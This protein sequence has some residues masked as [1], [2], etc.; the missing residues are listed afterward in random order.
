MTNNYIDITCL[1]VNQPIGTFYVG[2]I[3]WMDLLS[4]SRKDIERIRSEEEGNIEGYFGIQRELSENRLKE[5]S[6][7]VSFE[8]ATFPNSIVISIDSIYYNSKNDN[9][10][11]NIISFENNILRLNNNGRIAKII[12]GQH[13][14]FGIEKYI[15]EYPLFNDNYVFDLI[16][17]IFID[18]DEEYQSN[19]FAT[20]NKAQTKVN[21]SLVYDLYSLA[22]SR[23][24]QRTVHNIVKLLNEDN[25]S[26]FYRLIKRL[27]K[28]EF[29][30]ETIAQATLADTIVNYISLHPSYDR[31]LL[32]KGK[33]L[34]I[35]SGLEEER[36]FF[37][38]WFIN[39]KEEVNIAKVIWN[40][41]SVIKEKWPLAWGNPQ[42]ILTK[43]TGIIALMRFLK[44]IYSKEGVGKV[45]SKIE[46]KMI[47][48]KIQ[49]NDNDFVNEK[50]KAGGIGQADLY[51]DL[52][53]KSG[54]NNIE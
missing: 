3:K 49:L 15:T 34:K 33:E 14:L 7:F 50:Y 29:K 26:P 45:I 13:R 53:E 24:P 43:S 27:G 41:F 54:L 10:E 20:I 18:I 47:I 44:D 31:D 9:I 2:V 42:Y 37:R 22:K 8:D 40:Y 32:R 38:N 16:V 28:A 4:I 51:K 35:V 46:F 39:E 36:F 1:P 19:I 25:A 48:D 21:K 6:Q 52:K 5:I 30:S 17:T 23:S 12:D 11:E